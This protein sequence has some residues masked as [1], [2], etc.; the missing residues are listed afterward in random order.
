MEASKDN[1]SLDILLKEYD[2]VSEW[3]RSLFLSSEK[4]IGFGVALVTV[5]LSYGLKEKVYEVLLLLPIV[6]SG[7]L[8]Y[9]AHLTTGLRAVAGY[10]KYLEE[11]INEALGGEYLLWESHLAKS[12]HRL[13]GQKLIHLVSA[14]LYLLSIWLSLQTAWQFYRREIFYSLVIINLVF[15]TGIIISVVEMY[16]VF[17]RIYQSSKSIVEQNKESRGEEVKN[18]RRELPAGVQKVLNKRTPKRSLNRTPR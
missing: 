13:I 5:G 15:F 18:E 12:Q 1:S 3:V 10:K 6:L 14:I 11:R 7:V 2:Q 16:R 17:D 9:A 4:L 8:L